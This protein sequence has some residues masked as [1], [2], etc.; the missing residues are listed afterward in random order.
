MPSDSKKLT[1]VVLLDLS[2][3]FD[4]IDHPRLLAKSQTLGVSVAALGW[5]KSYLS[6]LKQYVQIRTEISGLRVANYGVPQGSILGSALCNIYIKD[7]PT[8]PETGFLEYFVDDSKLYLSF[9]LRNADF[10]ALKI[11]KDLKKALRGAVITASYKE[12]KVVTAGD[13]PQWVPDGF[14][15]EKELSPVPSEK[16]LGLQVDASSSL[17]TLFPLVYLT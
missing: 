1:L 10:V 8:V 6:E 15:I 4:T 14:R 13:T 2:K 12:D 17:R 11:T 3:A 7:F 16:Y 5:F 9:L